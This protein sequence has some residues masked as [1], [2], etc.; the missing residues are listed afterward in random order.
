MERL[1][2]IRQ[3]AKEC[4][5]GRADR[6]GTDWLISEVESLRVKLKESETILG[7]WQ[8][9]FGT[10]QLSHAQAR[11]EAQN[12]LIESLRQQLEVMKAAN[13]PAHPQEHK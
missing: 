11:L 12:A 8:S 9:V 2:E 1:E 5:K 4:G 6:N 13:A 3:W 7:A 10:S